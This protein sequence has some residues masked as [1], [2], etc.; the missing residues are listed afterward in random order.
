[1]RKQAAFLTVAI[2]APVFGQTPAFDVISVKPYVVGSRRGANVGCSNERFLS[3]GFPLVATIQFAYG[4]REFQV[5]KMP[6]WTEASDGYYEIEAKAAAS[7]SESQCKLMVQKLL[8]DR[9]KMAVHWEPRETPVYHLVVAKNGLKMQKASESDEG[10]DIKITFN[11][12]LMGTPLAA[13]DAKPTKG[14]TMPELALTLSAFTSG[15]PVIDKTGIEGAYKVALAF[16]YAL[17]GGQPLSDDPDVYTAVQ[18]QLGLKLEPVKE[19]VQMLVVDH[20]EKPG[21]N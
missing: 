15:Q 18:Q 3:Y 7:V 21:A 16:S 17:P 20:M 13:P 1:M 4:L 5:P 19:Q 11:G 12:R 6:S 9:F 10:T 8:A 2:L 14:R